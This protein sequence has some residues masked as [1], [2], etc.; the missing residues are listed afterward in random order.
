MESVLQP[1]EAPSARRPTSRPAAAAVPPA[2]PADRSAENGQGRPLPTKGQQTR[3]AI[4][5]AALDQASKAG[6]EGLT[7]GA[8][9][10]RMRMSKSG[11]F[12]HF[13]S[14][15]ELQI[16]VLKAYEQRFVDE[17]LKAALKAP[18]GLPRL[19]AVLDRW[20]ER[21]VIEASHGCIW[22]S[23]ASEYDDRPGPV[24][25]ELVQMVRG[26]RGE[27]DRAVG[28]A[29]EAGELASD[30]DVADL[31][32]DLNGVILVLHHDA[33]LMHS[34][35]CAAR[36]RR[37]IDRLLE[38]CRPRPANPAPADGGAPGRPAGAARSAT[39]S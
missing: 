29:I 30:T 20:V 25:D 26:W 36:A 16:A 34:H 9:A 33:R 23:G 24:R 31:T 14:R 38:S 8:L 10:D 7:I 39:L 22:I 15:E 27:L 32:F 37:S 35:D 4:V 1:E 2:R 19:R 6:L 11:V 13:G 17:V 3:Q 12:A 28:Q 21:T 5:E 18:R